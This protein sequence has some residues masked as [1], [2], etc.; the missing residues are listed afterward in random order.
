MAEVVLTLL[1]A[2]ALAGAAVWHHTRPGVIAPARREIRPG[3]W[4]FQPVC[5][6]H[7]PLTAG[8]LTQYTRVC[9]E[10]VLHE[11]EHG[12]AVGEA[13]LRVV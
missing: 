11:R 3:L 8:W 13:F 1:L 9:N 4:E 7:G 5:S 2:A 12:C 6:R 10:A